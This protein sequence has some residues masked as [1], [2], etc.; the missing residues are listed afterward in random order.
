MIKVRFML[1]GLDNASDELVNN[2]KVELLLSKSHFYRINLFIRFME[3]K[4]GICIS[5]KVK[6]KTRNVYNI[7]FQKEECDKIKSIFHQ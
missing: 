1:I 4:L 3:G 5:Y 2:K 6:D 7:N